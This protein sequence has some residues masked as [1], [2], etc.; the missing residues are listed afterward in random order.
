MNKS[1]QISR[2][3]VL[4]GLGTAVALPMLDAMLP[5]AAWA[6]GGKKRGPVRMAFVYVPNGQHMP[7][8]TPKADGPGWELPYIMEPFASVKDRLL[9]LT[10]L[11]QHHARAN[12]DGPGDHARA[13]SA[14]LTGAQPFKTHGA[15]IKVGVSVDQVAAAKIGRQTRFP[16]LELGCDRGAQAGSCDSGYSCAYSTNIS[17][18]S[19][20]TPQ[21]KEIDPKLAFERLFADGDPKSRRTKYRQSVLDHVLEDARDLKSKL[22]MKDQRKLDEYL[23]SVRELETRIAVAGQEEDRELP[24]YPKPDGIPKDYAEHIRLMYDVMALAFQGDL[25]RVA[26]FV[27]ANEGSNRTYK[28]IGVSEGHHHLS[29]HGGDEEKQMK[30]REINRFHAQQFAYFLE[31]LA[32]VSEGE[33]TLLD[34][35]M[36]L[37]GSGI[38]DGNRHNHHDLP[39]LLAGAGGGTIKTDRHMRYKEETPLNNLFLSM[40]D[41]VDSSV[42]ELGDSDGRLSGLV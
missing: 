29:H 36:I 9:V 13:L 16:S 10:G 31:K 18:R 17:W 5:A 12:G 11:A 28:S 26:T 25:T 6:A 2:R 34:N 14:F 37:Y 38:G 19:A 3:T 30:I 15:D 33:R 1:W 23:N 21:A 7:D 22:G 40:L 32:A 4:R 42:E 35:S 20:T 39:I 41:R 8:W 27:V 24:E